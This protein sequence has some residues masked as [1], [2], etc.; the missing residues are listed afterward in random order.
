MLSRGTA[1]SQMKRC[2]CDHRVFYSKDI[3]LGLRWLKSSDSMGEISLA[4]VLRLRA[5]SA[6]L[7]DKGVR[8]FAQD[9]EFVEVLR[10]TPQTS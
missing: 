7:R 10:K 3:V 4:G 2:T 9:D 5:P 1:I 8:R 6:V